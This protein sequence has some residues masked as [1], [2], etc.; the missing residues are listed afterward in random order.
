MLSRWLRPCITSKRDGLCNS[1]IIAAGT[2]VARTVIFDAHPLELV[3]SAAQLID[4]VAIESGLIVPI[5]AAPRFHLGIPAALLAVFV[6]ALGK[7]L[8]QR[9]GALFELVAITFVGFM[10]YYVI[11]H[12]FNPAEEVSSSPGTFLERGVLTNAILMFGVLLYMGGQG[13]K[14]QTWIFAG[15]FAVVRIALLDVLISSPLAAPHDV[16]SVRI[17]NALLMPYGLPVIWLGLF[18]RVLAE[19]GRDRIVPY[20]YGAVLLFFFAWISL[21]VRQ[22]F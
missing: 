12:A 11:R 6:Y 16:V 22:L 3:R 14:R 10:G 19:R 15:G 5:A 8:Q 21:N 20:A 17:L 4:V 13:F 1:N 9:A 2:A 18:A 7:E